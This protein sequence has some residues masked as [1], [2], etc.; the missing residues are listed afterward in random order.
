MIRGGEG[1]VQHVIRKCEGCAAVET[2]Q[3]LQSVIRVG[4][5]MIRGV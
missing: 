2:G 5:G 4:E 3:I 1:G